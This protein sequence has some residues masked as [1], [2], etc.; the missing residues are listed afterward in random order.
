MF[1]SI[2]YWIGLNG[3][4]PAQF[5]SGFGNDIP[6]AI[7]TG[8]PTMIVLARKMDKHHHEHLALIQKHHD[9]ILK[10]KSGQSL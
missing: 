4:S 1:H 10:I 5:W 8:L 9:E 2:L 6:L 3:G 7:V